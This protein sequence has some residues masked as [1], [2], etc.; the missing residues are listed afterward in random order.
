MDIVA[1]PTPRYRGSRLSARMALLGGNSSTAKPCS[2][3]ASAIHSQLGANTN[4]SV[5]KVDR[6]PANTMSLTR[7]LRSV[8]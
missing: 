8:R 3:D 4:M 5:V 2:S 7:P 6:N 1:K